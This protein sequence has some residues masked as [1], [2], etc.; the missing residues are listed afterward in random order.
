MI[1]KGNIFNSL[2]ILTFHGNF[3]KKSDQ[4]NILL[5]LPKT[6]GPFGITEFKGLLKKRFNLLEYDD[7]LSEKTKV[8][9]QSKVITFEQKALAIS[10]ALKKWQDVK[11]HIIGHSTGCGLGTFLAKHN[12]ES[13]KSII[14]INP[15]NKQDKDFRFLQNRRI[16]NF[17]ILDR[18]SYLQSEY[19]LLYSASY[20]KKFNEEFYNHIDKQKNINIDVASISNRLQTILNCNIGDEL[21]KLELPKLLIN[22]V[23]DKLMKIHHGIELHKICNNSKLISLKSGGHMLTETRAKD[24]NVHISYFINSLGK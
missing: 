9:S 19:K 1:N 17:K 11:F 4:A 18:I 16:K 2:D 13:C 5:L 8:F 3:Y 23:D 21:C 7:V 6:R 24:L 20:I 10:N 14:L 12:K 15:W 22:S